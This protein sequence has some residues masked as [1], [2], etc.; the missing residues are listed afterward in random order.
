MNRPHSNSGQRGSATSDS[1]FTDV[2]F[3]CA[4]DLWIDLSR[5]RLERL[6]ERVPLPEIPLGV[7]FYLWERRG[8]PVT[9]SELHARFW[10]AQEQDSFER[11]LHTTMRKLRQAIDDDARSPRLIESMDGGAYRWIG[12]HPQPVRS[13]RGGDA[14]GAA[15]GDESAPSI[16]AI[17]LVRSSR[18]ATLAVL[19]IALAM[20]LLTWQSRSRTAI[21]ITLPLTTAASHTLR[22]FLL[23]RLAHLP[24]LAQVRVEN[25]DRADAPA[26]A[27]ID[28]GSQTHAVPLQNNPEAAEELLV[29]AAMVSTPR[30]DLY[31]AARL[32]QAPHEWLEVSSQLATTHLDH[33][34]AQRSIAQ[35]AR[36]AALQPGYSS[37]WL[38]LAQAHI[39][40]AR[41]QDPGDEHQQ[42]A[43][44]ALR[45]AIDADPRS[46]LA[47][48]TLA[49][50]LYWHQ[51]DAT[52]AERW[53]A[54]A[55][56]VAPRDHRVQHAVA[57]KEL[58]HGNATL[59]LA[60]M[61]AAA[62]ANPLDSE[63]QS[64]W[65]WFYYRTGNFEGAVRQCRRAAGL[66]KPDP[67]A[68]E[69]ELRSLAMLHRFDE[70]WTLLSD[71]PPAWLSPG[72]KA[73][74]SLLPPQ[75]AYGEAML[76]SMREREPVAHLIGS[77]PELSVLRQDPEL[78]PLF[79]PP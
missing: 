4:G 52:A 9:R 47:I 6:G 66:A 19:G 28:D 36:A 37:A 1:P 22:D 68:S 20:A 79:A 49:N 8:Q 77:T 5:H 57:W 78:A 23:D 41:Q 27:T 65:G 45:R 2:T 70:A 7:L 15:D 33:D 76:K 21:T 18:W 46:L 50:H 26:V 3:W 43:R 14:F 60:Q 34:A 62:S 63:L 48:V 12:P 10:A 54:I 35:L 71:T 64:D 67:S 25:T 40:L 73:R 55:Q 30:H 29:R 59:A 16:P 74:L 38:A 24:D 32:A 17:M 69:C 53:F 42:C 56:T 51:W 11:K 31:T 75:R 39:A 61:T 13:K 44:I 72:A 58:S